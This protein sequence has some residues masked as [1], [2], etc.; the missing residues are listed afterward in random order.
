MNPDRKKYVAKE[1]LQKFREL[2]ADKADFA[3][4]MTAFRESDLEIRREVATGLLAIA[5]DRAEDAFQRRFALMVLASM[6]RTFQLMNDG[7]T[8]DRLDDLVDHPLSDR[9]RQD[10]NADSNADADIRYGA[11]LALIGVNR[12]R[13]LQKLELLLQSC[14]DSAFA[15]QLCRMRARFSSGHPDGSQS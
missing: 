4:K 8:E 7:E 6:I 9:N 12:H 14:T 11:L 15:E 5:T 10:A 1:F 2:S 13:G 3:S